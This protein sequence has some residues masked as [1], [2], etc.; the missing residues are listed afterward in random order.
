MTK[1]YLLGAGASLGNNPSKPDNLSPPSSYEFFTKGR[2]YQILPSDDF[3]DLCNAI[4]KH[5]GTNQPIESLSESALEIEIENFLGD[6]AERHESKRDKKA[7]AALSQSYYFIYELLRT[8]S[9]FHYPELERDFYQELA[10][11]FKRNRYSII[12]LNYDNLLENSMLAEGLGCN[13]GFKRMTND[14]RNVPI[15]KVHGSI[16]WFNYLT[17]NIAFGKSGDFIDVIRSVH[18]TIVTNNFSDGERQS[19]RVKPPS[20]LQEI[21]YRELAKARDELYEPALVPPISSYKIYNKNSDYKNAWNFASSMLEHASELVVIGS[22][23]RSQDDKLCSIIEDGVSSNIDVTLA[24]GESTLDV[25]ERLTDLIGNPQ[26][27][28]YRY[29]SDYVKNELH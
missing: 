14:G 28:E 11:E 27:T 1:C 22:S 13:Y 2:K 7:Q 10:K 23:V 18:G 8:C 12:S 21:P 25:K 6:L 19:L 15:A 24:V 5:I 9:S 29:F 20:E 17:K 4:Q 16:N 3:P 26:F